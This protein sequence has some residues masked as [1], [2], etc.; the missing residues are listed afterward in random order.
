MHDDDPELFE[1][2]LQLFCIFA[3]FE[4]CILVTIQLRTLADKHDLWPV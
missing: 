2:M 4:R 1:I 3:D